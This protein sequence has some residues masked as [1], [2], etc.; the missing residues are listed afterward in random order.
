MSTR[1]LPSPTKQ[2]LCKISGQRP[3][4][5]GHQKSSQDT[6][7]R[8]APSI[9]TSAHG[10]R[11][12]SR[13]CSKSPID[14]GNRQVLQECASHM[15]TTRSFNNYAPKTGG[16]PQTIGLSWS[17]RQAACRKPHSNLHA[18][19]N[20]IANCIAYAYAHMQTTSRDPHKA[21]IIVRCSSATPSSPCGNWP[22]PL[23]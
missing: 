2:H 5:T 13:T 3:W 12:I 17:R 18:H 15:T 14:V 10:A 20:Y 21:A 23:E 16:I 11:N 9:Y 8:H 6:F 4:P 7:A 19:A 1:S 22:P